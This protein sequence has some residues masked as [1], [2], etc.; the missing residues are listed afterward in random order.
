MQKL[1][2]D[3]RKK[4]VDTF[5]FLMLFSKQINYDMT[6]GSWTQNFT[7]DKYFLSLSLTNIK[8]NTTF[9]VD[10]SNDYYIFIPYNKK[11]YTLNVA[12]YI[13]LLL[14]K[15]KLIY[16]EN[17]NQQITSVPN[18]IELLLTTTDFTILKNAI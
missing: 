13:K 7:W 3:N 5:T 2:N 8:N 11:F 17:T 14:S 1:L 10:Q 18:N 12:D 15:N 4:F 9:I 6:T 16:D